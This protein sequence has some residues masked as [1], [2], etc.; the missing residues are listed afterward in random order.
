MDINFSNI[1]NK[2]KIQ[3][4]CVPCI[5]EVSLKYF[6]DALKIDEVNAEY[7]RVKK[8]Y[9]ED[10]ENTELKA[11]FDG[12]KQRYLELKEKELNALNEFIKIIKEEMETEPYAVI[13][14]SK[15]FNKVKELSGIKDPWRDLKA[16]SNLIM[17]NLDQDLRTYIFSIKNPRARLRTALIFSAM[18]NTI[19]FGTAMH[20]VDLKFSFEYFMEEFEKFQE[21]GFAIDEFDLFYEKI[22]DL[23]PKKKD[24]LREEAEYEEEYDIYEEGAEEDNN[25]NGSEENGNGLSDI[26]GENDYD[27]ENNEE[28]EDE[29]IIIDSGLKPDPKSQIL[30]AE[31]EV[32]DDKIEPDNNVEVDEEVF[33]NQPPMLILLDNAGE[34]VIDK[35]LIEVIKDMGINITAV[36]KSEPVSNDATLEDAK[37]IDLDLVCN[38]IGTGTSDLGFNPNHASDEFLNMLATAPLII[39]KGQANFESINTFRESIKELEIFLLAK[40]KCHINAS[41]AGVNVGDYVLWYMK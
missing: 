28:A 15:T 13:I 26:A 6:R 22:L 12:I 29:E 27:G 2:Y 8:L 7:L 34:I 40:F 17:L 41:L 1:F 21:K 4:A 18:A 3:A 10:P 31:I 38:V 32:E 37:E 30:E 33:I 5:L 35:I 25:I 11:K 24:L 19:D 9:E 23:S 14:A 36:V 20:K 16:M 39:A